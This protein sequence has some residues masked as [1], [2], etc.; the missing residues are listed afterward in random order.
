MVVSKLEKAKRSRVAHRTWAQRTIEEA[1]AIMD[2]NST[3][4][5]DSLTKADCIRLADLCDRLEEKINDIAKKDDEIEDMCDMDDME[6]EVEAACTEMSELKAG[7]R[8][9][10]RFIKTRSSSSSGGRTGRHLAL[11]SYHVLTSR[12]SLAIKIY[13][14]HTLNSSPSLFITMIQ[15]RT[16][17]ECSIWLDHYEAKHSRSS[18]HSQ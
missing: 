13:G 12:R 17:N 5:M 1:T 15:S 14:R 2:S 11:F 18:H 10:E 7:L 4:A 9:V 6:T 8:K 16:S 3:G